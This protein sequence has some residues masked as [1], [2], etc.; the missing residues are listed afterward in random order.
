M[1]LKEKGFYVTGTLRRKRGGPEL[2]N[3]KK[4][5]EIPKKSDIP[6]TKSGINAFYVMILN[7]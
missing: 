5:L 4:L 6:Y 1:K 7:Q 2:M 3:Y